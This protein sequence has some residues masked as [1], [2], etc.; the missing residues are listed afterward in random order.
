MSKKTICLDFDGVLHNFQEP[1]KG[2][3][4]IEGEPI[5][6]MEEFLWD[7]HSVQKLGQD[8][9]EVAIFS[10][11]NE[12][13]EGILAMKK[14]LLLSFSRKWASNEVVGDFVNGLQFPT[15][16]PPAIVY[17]DDRGMTFTGTFPDVKALLSFEPWN[18]R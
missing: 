6:G 16:K 8:T 7:L 14:W 18:R 3:T 10:T 11:R 5:P 2:P 4:V 15:M 17:L 13:L 1:W 9:V 12:S